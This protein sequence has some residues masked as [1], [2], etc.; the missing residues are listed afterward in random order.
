MTQVN[1]GLPFWRKL[2]QSRPEF[3]LHGSFYFI[4]NTVC[5][6]KLILRFRLHGSYDA[7]RGGHIRDAMVDFTGGLSETY[8][9]RKEEEIPDDL[10]EIMK[11]S[12]SMSSQIG[13]YIWV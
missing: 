7:L 3:Y 8:N 4:T 10:F 12:V 5:P 13:C 1:S 6:Y 2:M 11:K 9:L